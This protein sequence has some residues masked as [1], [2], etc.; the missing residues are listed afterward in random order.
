ML[1]LQSG[2]GV[3]SHSILLE[4][5]GR[6]PSVFKFS[7]QFSL[8]LSQI[9]FKLWMAIQSDGAHFEVTSHHFMNRMKSQGFHNISVYSFNDRNQWQSISKRF[10]KTFWT[11]L[12]SPLTRSGSR[13]SI[14]LDCT[15]TSL[16]AKDSI[17]FSID[18]TLRTGVI[19][20]LSKVMGF[21]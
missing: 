5:L 1:S 7:M 15:Q 20:F 12:S 19:L 11:V 17:S 9:L 14:C 4:L 6:Y 16:Q 8:C 21:S 2:Q 18:W 3:A 10:S 13:P